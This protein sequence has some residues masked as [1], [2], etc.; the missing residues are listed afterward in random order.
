VNLHEYQCKALFAEYGISI[1]RGRVAASEREARAVARDLGGHVVVKAQVLVGGRGKAGGVKLARNVNE[2]GNSAAEILASRIAGLPV[3]EVLVDEAIRIQSEIYLGITNDRDARR[4]VIMASAD[5]GVD[6][7][8]VNRQTPEK[9]IREHIDPFLG[10][11]IYQARNLASGIELPRAFWPEFV[12]IAFG[13]HT[14]FVETDAT[15]AEINP[16]VVTEGKRLVAVDGKI[17]LDENALFRHR[18]LAKAR[19]MEAES[20]EETEA[21]K[22]GFSYV[23]LDGDIGCL[24]NGAGLAMGTMDIVKHF[25]GSPANFLDIGGGASPEKVSTALRMILR[26][27]RVNALL[28]NIFGGITRCDDVARGILAAM[29]GVEVSIP[30]VARLVGTNEK[31]GRRLLAES[32]MVMALSLA[33]AAQ[34]VVAAASGPDVVT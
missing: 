18:E 2:A 5:G 7:E 20:P 6:I 16:L 1:P 19:D 29:D 13:L 3:R 22:H 17:V 10:I 34:R 23:A 4:P 25:G 30:I 33:E 27:Q 15:L 12:D 14:A 32:K 31:E 26:D 24:V 9:I 8:E 28:I 21:R 11:R